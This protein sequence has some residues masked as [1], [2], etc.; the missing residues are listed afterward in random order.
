MFA[1]LLKLIEARSRAQPRADGLVRMASVAVAP[2]FDIYFPM[3]G[4]FA[5]HAE[6]KPKL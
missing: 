1:R 6:R 2:N 4:V 5:L 3:A